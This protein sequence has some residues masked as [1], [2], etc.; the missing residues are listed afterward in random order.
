M[1]RHTAIA[2]RIAIAAQLVVAVLAI[3][4]TVVFIYVL[5]HT[6]PAPGSSEQPRPAITQGEVDR[7]M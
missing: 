1:L 7:G 5:L 4:A 3:V 6:P 2:R